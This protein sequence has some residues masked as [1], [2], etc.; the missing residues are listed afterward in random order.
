MYFFIIDLLIDI[1]GIITSSITNKRQTSQPPVTAQQSQVDFQDAD[2][3]SAQKKEDI[4][5]CPFCAENIVAEAII[6]RH[7]GRILEEK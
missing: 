1:I 4:I 3:L 7:C 6:C 5:D 2:K